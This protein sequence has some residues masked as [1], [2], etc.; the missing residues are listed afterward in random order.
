VNFHSVAKLHINKE[1]RCDDEKVAAIQNKKLQLS[2]ARF[3]RA[4]ILSA[5]RIV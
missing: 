4:Q 2:D 1:F 5:L 3:M